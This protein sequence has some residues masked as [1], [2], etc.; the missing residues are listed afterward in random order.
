MITVH[1]RVHQMILK[2]ILRI[3]VYTVRLELLSLLMQV[4]PFK[5]YA[6]VNYLVGI[7]ISHLIYTSSS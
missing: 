6:T 4:L 3:R 5:M 7:T 1:P 2:D